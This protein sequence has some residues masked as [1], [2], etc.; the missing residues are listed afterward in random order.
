MSLTPKTRALV[1]ACGAIGGHLDPE[2]D[3][4]TRHL[5]HST[6]VS[7]APARQGQAPHTA[8]WLLA[9]LCRGRICRAMPRFPGQNTCESLQAAVHPEQSAQV[10]SGVEASADVQATP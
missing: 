1:L 7:S 3:P 9:P 6:T 4:L 2:H 5:N 8:E 10:P